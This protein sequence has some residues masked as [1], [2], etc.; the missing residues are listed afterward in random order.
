MPVA[1]KENAPLANSEYRRAVKTRMQKLMQSCI[2]ERS[3]PCRQMKDWLVSAKCEPLQK[4]VSKFLK[5]ADYRTFIILT[6][7]VY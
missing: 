6:N 1:G 3:I 4:S 5:A 2:I 7:H